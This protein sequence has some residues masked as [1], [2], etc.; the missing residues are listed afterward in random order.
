[1]THALRFE[2][3]LLLKGNGLAEIAPDLWPIAVFTLVVA[4]IAFWSYRQT[5]D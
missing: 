2:R 4:V 5:L 3:G 1:M